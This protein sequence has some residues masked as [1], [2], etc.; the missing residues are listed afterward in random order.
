MTPKG[1][2]LLPGPFLL[3]AGVPGEEGPG[4]GAG[5]GEAPGELGNALA[6]GGAGALVGNEVGGKPFP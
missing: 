6:V 3:L 2:G 1:P 5:L 4:D